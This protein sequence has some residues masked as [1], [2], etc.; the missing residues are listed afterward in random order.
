MARKLKWPDDRGDFVDTDPS[1]ET[2]PDG[3]GR[4]TFKPGDVIEVEDAD[5]ADH[6]LDRGWTDVS[7]DDDVEVGTAD[8]DDALDYETF[9]AKGYQD[10]VDAVKAG[11]VDDHLDRIADEDESTNV[12]DAV[13]ARQE[14]LGQG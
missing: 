7:E 12:Q 1:R 3:V 4:V 6:Y 14:E 13:E 2:V 9:Q 11:K 5:T 8:Q 10:R